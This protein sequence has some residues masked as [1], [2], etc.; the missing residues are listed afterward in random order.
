MKPWKLAEKQVADLF[1]GVRRVRI[2]YGESI[3]DV[4]HPYLAIEV[5]YGKQVPKWTHVKRPTC[6]GEF[7]LIPSGM[8]SWSILS[9]AFDDVV[10]RRE[11]FLWKG[12]AQAHAYSPGKVPMLCL[13]P[14]NF[15][16]FVV[17]LRRDD[18]NRG[19]HIRLA[20]QERIG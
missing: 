6:N 10:Q 17:V 20:P 15:R 5:K 3:E 12:I 4:S 14:P 8:F 13:K 1:G 9:F 7:V 11:D 18:Y 16:G 19:P 2:N